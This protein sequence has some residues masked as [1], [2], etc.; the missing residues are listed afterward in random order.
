MPEFSRFEQSLRE[1]RT[2]RSRA[3]ITGTLGEAAA[4]MEGTFEVISESEDGDVYR[5]SNFAS[6]AVDQSAMDRLQEVLA[7][8]MALPEDFVAFWRRWSRAVLVLR[9]DFWLMSPAQMVEVATYRARFSP[10]CSGHLGKHR[11]IP[12]AEINHETEDYAAL[13][14]RAEDSMWNVCYFS[15][16]Y[17]TESMEDDPGDEFGSDAS[18]SDWL[19]RVLSTDGWP[20]IPWWRG[21][22]LINRID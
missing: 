20:P 21:E 3:L 14:L 4:G 10:A 1:V 8:P 2:Y 11:V 22:S 6:P 17:W 7:V 9:C 19:E 13:R 18:F 5:A 16:E 12:F 15:H